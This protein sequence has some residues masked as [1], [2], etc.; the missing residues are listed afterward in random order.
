MS[1]R[2]TEARKFDGLKRW[3][4][5][6]RY[7]MAGR[8]IEDDWLV[9][10]AACGTGY[11]SR[12]LP[13]RYVGVDKISKE[14][15]II[16]RGSQYVQG[17]L[18]SLVYTSPVDAWLSFET[19]E[20]LDDPRQLVANS[21]QARH[22][23]CFSVPIYEGAENNPYHTRKYTRDDLDEMLVHKDWFSFYRAVQPG[24]YYLVFQTRIQARG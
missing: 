12:I 22:I 13:G 9:V 7:A 1:E 16:G 17:D 15:T 10:D 11:A 14:E 4:H 21:E 24:G 3:Q 19:I 20:H 5:V 18:N 6:Y 8:H 2:I 23:R